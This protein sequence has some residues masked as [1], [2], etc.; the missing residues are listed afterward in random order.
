MLSWYSFLNLRFGLDLCYSFNLRLQ[1]DHWRRKWLI[2]SDLLAEN[3]KCD[4]E[5]IS[6]RS[7]GIMAPAFMADDGDAKMI[8]SCI[9]LGNLDVAERATTSPHGADP[10]SEE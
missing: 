10:S 3:L 8:V 6:S 1:L 5:S 4:S 2:N 9:G 7:V